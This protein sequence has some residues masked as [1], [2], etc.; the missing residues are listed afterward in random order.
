[1][2][3]KKASATAEAT[4]PSSANDGPAEI[5]AATPPASSSSNA[6]PSSSSTTTAPT[7]RRAGNPTQNNSRAQ[8]NVESRGL[9]VYDVLIMLLVAAI[10]ALLARRINLMQDSQSGSDFPAQE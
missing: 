2:G 1:M 9:Q 8:G 4:S 7:R 6:G 5:A 10:A 3:Q